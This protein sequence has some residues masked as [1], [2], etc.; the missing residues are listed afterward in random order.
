MNLTDN[1]DEVISEYYDNELSKTK[2]IHLESR[3]ASSNSIKLVKLR[4][5]NFNKLVDLKLLKKQKETIFQQLCRF[6][7]GFL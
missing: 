1:L 7:Q 5:K 2:L 4:A 6:F 3:F